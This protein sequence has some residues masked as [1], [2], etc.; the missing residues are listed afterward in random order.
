MSTR[1]QAAQQPVDDFWMPK[2]YAANSLA[3]VCKVRIFNRGLG[4]VGQSVDQARFMW[5][6]LLTYPCTRAHLDIFGAHTIA[7]RNKKGRT[8]SQFDLSHS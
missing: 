6:I 1:K 8:P 4:H 2:E 7:C 5:R 3:N